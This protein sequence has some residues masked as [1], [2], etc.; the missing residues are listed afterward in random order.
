MIVVKIELHSA[1]THKITEIGRMYIC[2]DGTCIDPSKGNYDV[3]VNRKGSKKIPNPL[4]KE[5]PKYLRKGKVLNY[6]RLSYNVWK[7][8]A[9]ALK[10]VF[11]EEK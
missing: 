2:N 3:Y 6:P 4:I 5:N 11:P 8:I 9:R 1:I 10:S 7:L